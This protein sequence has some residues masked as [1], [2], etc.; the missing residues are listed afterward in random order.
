MKLA[1]YDKSGLYNGL[2]SPYDQCVYMWKISW[3]SFMSGVVCL[4]HNHYSLLPVPIGV[5]FT[6]MLYWY[7]ADL[8]WRRNL[9]ISYVVCA[10]SYQVW[11]A[12]DAEYMIPYYIF[13]TLGAACYPIGW[14]FHIQGDTWG[15]TLAHSGIHILANIGNII[16]YSGTIKP[17]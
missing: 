17:I 11:R 3:L 4:F 5:W 16:L 12:V 13:T 6:S 9:D 1:Q 7:H 10:L 8:S 14:Y 2:V 15:G